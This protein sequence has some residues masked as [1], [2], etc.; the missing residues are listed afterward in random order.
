MIVFRKTDT[1]AR[2][3]LFAVL[4]RAAALARM[5]RRPGA[6]PLDELTDPAF[7]LTRRGALAAGAGLA[8]AAP[9]RS[10][11]RSDSRVA[12]IGCGIAGLVV[13]DRL[14]A[15]GLR[16]V[17]L[18]EANQRIGGR[19][20]S[21]RGVVGEGS[22]VELGGSFINSDHADIL[23]LAH[24]FQL[25]LE[26]GTASTLEPTFY[27]DGAARGLTEIAAASQGLL[28]HLERVKALPKL[29]Q[30][31]LSA[32]AV[33]DAADV[34]GWMRRLLDLGLTQE[35]GLEPDRMSALYLINSFTGRHMGQNGLFGSDQRYQ[36]AG[37]NDRLPAALA[38][39]LSTRISL[40][41][42]LVALRPEGRAYRAIF[43]GGQEVVA[44]IIVL[45]LPL[46]VLRGV[47]LGVPLPPL[48]R[49]AIAQTSYGSN[50][51][52]FAGVSARPWRA[53]GQS[54]E[55]LNDLGYQ[56][57]WEDH[58]KPGEG[59]GALTI[60]AGGRLGLGFRNGSSLERARAATLSLEPAL[61]GAATGFTGLATRM[62]WPS[63]PYVGGSYTCFAPGQYEGF[64]GAFAPAGGVFFAGEHASETSS[65]YMNG[66]AESGR[67]TAE[68]IQRALG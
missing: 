14:V 51:K 4:R 56:T 54:G 7:P 19:M 33:M 46:T 16:H 67:I 1:L 42:R 53:R 8:I 5:A 66:G 61:A 44:D 39:G 35:M 3:P 37:G 62:H 64:S 48:T 9:R 60:F 34:S 17:T 40:G 2:T 38:S 30:D 25:P 21:G 12:V 68:A 15:A 13:A 27:A 29:R 32:A 47:D 22:V 45:A 11:A 52:L 10:M 31:A 50:A 65:G 20:L 26:D 18:H 41:Q 55:C 24:R 43:A 63:N 6:R 57:V 28:A 59:P 36:I 23:A 49:R 58:A